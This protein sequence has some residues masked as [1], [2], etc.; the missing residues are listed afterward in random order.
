VTKPKQ[1]FAPMPARACADSTLSGLQM[2]VLAV[3]ALHD[4]LGRNGQG[5]WA[6]QRTL[7]SMIGCDYTRLSDAI[8][9]LKASGYIKVG[10]NKNDRRMQTFSVIY[11]EQDA[12]LIGKPSRD[13]ALPNGKPSPA[14]SLPDSLP[15]S[16]TFHSGINKIGS[17]IDRKEIPR[18]GERNSVET[19]CPVG[20]G[21]ESE[22]NSGEP[23]RASHAVGLQSESKPEKPYNAGA[24]LA[25]FERSLRRGSKEYL[26][27]EVAD[28]LAVLAEDYGTGDPVAGR[29]WRL[30]SDFEFPL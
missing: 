4:R 18:S 2:R 30:L 23:A 6:S 19:A 21:G 12:L 14:D 26:T 5:C 25:V 8:T 13:K 22:R 24:T 1:V 7:A 29:A 10:R 16:D 20:H 17:L 3:I 9:R 11:C 28:E 15:P 27:R